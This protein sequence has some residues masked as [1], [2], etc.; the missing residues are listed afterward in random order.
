MERP[1]IFE[2]DQRLVGVLAEP[3]GSARGAG[4]VLLHGWSGYRIGPHR[5]LVDAARAL[6]SAG[7]HTLRFDLRGRG[8]SSG[9]PA[10][11]DL[12]GMI[13]DARAARRL[14]IEQCGVRQTY[15][16]GICSGGNVALG[17]ASLDKGVDGLLLWSTPLFAPYKSKSQ[18]VARRGMF[19]AEYARKLFRRETYAKLVRGRLRLGIIARI[20]FGKRRPADAGRDPRDSHRDI[21]KDLRGYPGRALFIY[22][23]R[24]D[25]AI[26]APELYENFC[27]EQGIPAAFHTLEGANHSYYSVAWANE[28]IRLTREWLEGRMD[29]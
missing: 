23:S 10:T 20:L 12:D 6:C 25:E 24:D 18:E 7:C 16:L 2:T 21:M 19:L 15:W 27:A 22:G 3:E 26:G 9:D 28:V 29:G 1:V 14:L 13:E 5:M 11:S 4:I 8:D 17:A